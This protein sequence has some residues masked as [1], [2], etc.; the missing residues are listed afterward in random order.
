[1]TEQKR[2][3]QADEDAEGNRPHRSGQA[4]LEAQHPGGEDDGQHVDGRSGVEERRGGAQPGAAL[5]DPR[6]EG[7]HGAGAHRQDGARDRRHRVGHR[8]VCPGPQVAQH[9]LLG[10][11]HRDGPGDE[12]RRYQA[13]EHVLPGVFVEHRQGLRRR[14]LDPGRVGGEEVE[15]QKGRQ[16]VQEL[17]RVAHGVASF[18]SQDVWWPWGHEPSPKKAPEW[19]G[20][21]LSSPESA[22]GCPRGRALCPMPPPCRPPPARG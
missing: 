21:G 14:P 6:E 19:P 20:A 7:Q 10:H 11:E 5:V 18:P 17:L 8:P 4:H 13:E 1:M 22:S 2:H 12:E 16:D 3:G 9:R 15:G